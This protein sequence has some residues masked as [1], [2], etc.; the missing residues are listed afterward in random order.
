M[1]ATVDKTPFTAY[2]TKYALTD[3]IIEVQ[4]AVHR[5]ADMIAVKSIGSHAYFHKEGRDWHYTKDSAIKQAEKMREA[6][7]KSIEKQKQ[8]IEQLKFT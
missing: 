5:G 3:G 8:R 1:T 7:I 2:I 4:D 6:K